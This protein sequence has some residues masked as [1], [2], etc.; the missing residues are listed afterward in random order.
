MQIL[1]D[2]MDF[3]SKRG[4]SLTHNNIMSNE[5]FIIHKIK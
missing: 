3:V 1:W 2:G 5:P 4:K